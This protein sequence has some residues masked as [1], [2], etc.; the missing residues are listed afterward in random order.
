MNEILVG[1]AA[2]TASAASYSQQWADVATKKFLNLG[3]HERLPSRKPSY[4][5]SRFA[6]ILYEWIMK[7]PTSSAWQKG[8]WNARLA[9]RSSSHFVA[10]G[11]AQTPFFLCLLKNRQISS[12]GDVA[13]LTAWLESYQFTVYP[14]A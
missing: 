11:K 13:K 8:P 6:T 3:A 12:G 10:G 1:C 4:D 7:N 2:S 5:D 9:I 14:V